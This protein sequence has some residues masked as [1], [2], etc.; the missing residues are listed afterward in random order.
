MDDT[1]ILRAAAPARIVDRPAP[2]RAIVARMQGGDAIATLAPARDRAGAMDGREATGAGRHAHR[3][4][5]L[6]ADRTG[7]RRIQSAVMFADMRGFMRISEQMEPDEVF[8][9]LNEY[10]EL[11]TR[12]TLAHGGRVFHVAGD[13]LMAGFG[14]PDPRDDAPCR[15]LEAAREMLA[16]FGA[17]AEEWRRRLGVRTGLGIGIN[18]GDVIVGHVGSSGFRHYTM[19]G[20]TVNVA[21]RLSQRARAGE[22]LF[23]RSVM[24]AVA[25]HCPGMDCVELPP[26]QLRGREA[27]VEIY[28]LPAAMRI[29]L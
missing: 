6:P 10:F 1:G 5:A 17:M 21:S 14:V 4:D 16:R 7:H 18:A 20:D 29:E 23:S 15:A 19:V 25:R 22:A 27:P 28:C 2:D 8:P 9:L 24:D 12:I 3:P 13:E 26:L 11:L